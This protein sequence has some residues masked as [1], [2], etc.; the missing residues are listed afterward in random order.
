MLIHQNYCTQHKYTCTAH[1]HI[2]PLTTLANHFFLCLK[3]VGKQAIVQ[4][5]ARLLNDARG[6][7]AESTYV[8]F[9]MHMCYSGALHL[10]LFF[11]RVQR[12]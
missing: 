5:F 10:L 11:W 12:I 1:A 9:L 3:G 6:P 4:H 2:E 8:F 7:A